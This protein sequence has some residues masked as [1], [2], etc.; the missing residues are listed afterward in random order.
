MWALDLSPVLVCLQLRG[1][2]L[3]PSL[4]LAYP[5]CRGGLL[6]LL[7]LLLLLF[8]L[9]WL[10]G[11]VLSLPPAVTLSLMIPLALACRWRLRLGTP[12][13]HL[14]TFQ[15]SALLTTLL[16]LGMTFPFSRVSLLHLLSI[17]LLQ[18]H[19][20]VLPRVLPLLLSVQVLTL[21]PALNAIRPYPK[22]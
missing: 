17:V 10:L 7:P 11:L 22:P 5:L 2:P 13:G 16:L 4:V 15:S 14:W 19:P 18:L 1:S 21:G 6:L 8:R 20:S 3:D 9:P 12:L